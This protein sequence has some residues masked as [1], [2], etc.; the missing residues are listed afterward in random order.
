MAFDGATWPSPRPLQ[1]NSNADSRRRTRAVSLIRIGA[2]T[3]S[4]LLAFIGPAP[5]HRG[6][7]HSLSSVEVS[8]QILNYLPPASKIVLTNFPLLSLGFNYYAQFLH[9]FD[10]KSVT[11]PLL[12]EQLGL[13][14]PMRNVFDLRR[15][16]PILFITDENGN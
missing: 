4:A 12:L 14:P 7:T 3:S 2:V 6:E 15:F 11:L 9:L 10:L 16:D 1:S 8:M 5:L 13:A